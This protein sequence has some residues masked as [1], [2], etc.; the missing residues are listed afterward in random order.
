MDHPVDRRQAQALLLV[1][2]VSAA[3]LAD[4][5]AAL[6]QR[7]TLTE[8][9]GVMLGA[10]GAEHVADGVFFRFARH[11]RPDRR[12]ARGGDDVLDRHRRLGAPL[13]RA[14]LLCGV[15]RLRF[16]LFAGLG[17]RAG[18]FL[19]GGSAR[20]G[21]AIAARA[22]PSEEQGEEERPRHHG[23]SLAAPSGAGATSLEDPAQGVT[24]LTPLVRVSW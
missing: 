1:D 5:G 6:L 9:G 24:K 12:R 10:V 11:E 23:P 19:R 21:V 20:L 14:R 2:Q 4:V 13:F 8:V 3:E 7:A 22:A 16:R 15:R 17:G 18:R